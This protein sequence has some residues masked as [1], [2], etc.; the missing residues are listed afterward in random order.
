MNFALAACVAATLT[1]STLAGGGN[2]AAASTPAEAIACTQTPFV[3]EPSAET[4]YR[5]PSVVR[6]GSGALVAFAERRDNGIGDIGDFDIVQSRSVDRGCTW[7]DPV[8]I[9]DDGANRIS[10]PLPIF[11]S[12]TGNVLV[13]S[14]IAPQ[15]AGGRPKGLYLQTST[16]D[17]RTFSPLGD[18]PI[19]PSGAYKGGLTSPGHGIQLQI[20]HP[21][22]LLV[23]MGYRNA[24]GH[25]AYAIYSDDHGV[26][27]R[28][29]YDQ[30]DPSKA[31]QLIEGSVAELAS[32]DI[33]I[34][35]RN[36]IAGSAAGTTRQYAYSSDG[37]QTLRAP[38]ALMPLRVVNV[39]GSALSLNGPYAGRL[40]YSSPANTDPLL[41]RQMT[42]F[43]ST[44]DGATWGP[45]YP[46]TLEDTPD[47]YSDLVQDDD[48]VG[49]LYETGI[50]TWRERIVYRSIDLAE[51]TAPARAPARI[52]HYRST[53]PTPSDA[54]ARI[55]VAVAVDGTLRPPGRVTVT[56]DRGGLRGATSVR[57]SYSNAGI[58]T[59]TLPLLRR[60]KYA[61]TIRYSGTERIQPVSVSAGT[62]TVV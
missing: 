33:Y 9:A 17:G 19:R 5:I 11:D 28:T 38:F 35:Y 45:R 30:H 44:S 16:D 1:A 4:W 32:G 25:G 31:T 12:V 61:L 60:G 42:V 48:R 6:T 2:V 53:R 37:G 7:S 27:W 55:R 47:S 10:N 59:V 22:R 51:L 54:H 40:L 43:T 13:L 8:V 14:V 21:G 56:F 50:R 52:A 26:T 58:R 46:V 15:E 39:Q 41:R 23:P 62:L 18:A 49:V 29:G 34:T 57:L 20:S 3:S 24:K 36:N